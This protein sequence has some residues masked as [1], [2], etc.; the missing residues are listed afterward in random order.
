MSCAR[1]S[2]GNRL[3]AC[4]KTFEPYL[5]GLSKPCRSY[6]RLARSKACGRLQSDGARHLECDRSVRQEERFFLVPALSA[7]REPRC[8]RPA[9]SKRSM[10]DGAHIR[11]IA[12]CGKL[13]YP[14]PLPILNDGFQSCAA[15][16]SAR[17]YK[18][19]HRDLL[20]SDP[21][22]PVNINA[23]IKAETTAL[24]APLPPAETPFVNDAMLGQQTV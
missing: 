18:P 10:L 15:S 12:F 2:G 1:R 24:H 11:D 4:P 6:Q 17:P 7:I 21:A 8:R 5:Q 16:G 3:L 20:I 13:G 23:E 9:Q 14:V 19:H 22:A